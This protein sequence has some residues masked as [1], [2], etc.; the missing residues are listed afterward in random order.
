MASGNSRGTKVVLTGSV[1]VAAIWLM[2][3]FGGIGL[4][5]SGGGLLPGKGTEQSAQ[6]ESGIEDSEAKEQEAEEAQ[7][8]AEPEEEE[9]IEITESD[10]EVQEEEAGET[11]GESEAVQTGET[12]QAEDN[13]LRVTIKQKE[14]LIGDR[15]ITDPA[16]IVKE[17]QEMDGVLLR[18]DYADNEVWQQV[19]QALEDAGITY[20]T[21]VL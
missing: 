2:S 17:A 9:P 7:E 1:V 21:E 20:G 8:P 6:Q 12:Q 16:D 3:Q 13:V 11:A 14:I 15:I 5:G 10:S 19:I 4:G 18:D